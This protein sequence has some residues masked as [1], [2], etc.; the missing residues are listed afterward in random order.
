MSEEISP[1]PESRAIST[2]LYALT[3]DA[4]RYRA[5]RERY[6]GADF[7]QPHPAGKGTRCVL[8]FDWPENEPLSASLDNTVDRLR[9]T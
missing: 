5:L 3:Q 4:A 6:L 9:F 8:I 7:T 2:A 1:P